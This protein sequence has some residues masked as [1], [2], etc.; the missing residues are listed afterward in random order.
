M[1]GGNPWS[2][3]QRGTKGM[4]LGQAGKVEMFCTSF[5][6]GGPQN[7]DNGVSS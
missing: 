3:E 2:R 7:L 6:Y 1:T 5:N 4:L